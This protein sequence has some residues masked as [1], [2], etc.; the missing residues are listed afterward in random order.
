MIIKIPQNNIPERT[1]IIDILIGEFLGLSYSIEVSEATNYHLIF[2]EKEV[3]VEDNFFNHYQENLAYL[4]SEAIPVSVTF[5]ENQFT[6]ELDVPVLFGNEKIIVEDNHII[7]GNDIFAA[8]FF[9]LTRWEEYV[10][11]ARDIH[12]RFSAKDSL[13][14]KFDFL[15]RPIVNE[16]VEM[17][18]GMLAYLGYREQRK[19]RKY[20][21]VLTHDV[22]HLSYWKGPMRWMQVLG[23]DLIKRKSLLL[24]TKSI[25]DL[26]QT[27]LGIKND[28]YDTFDWI[29]DLSEAANIKSRF[30]FM[31]SDKSDN[32]NRYDIKS[33]LAIGILNKIK[34][35]G[36][37]IGF[38]PSFDSYNNPKRWKEEKERLE[39]TVELPIKEGRQHYLR[40]DSTVTWDIWNRNE[41]ESDLTLSFADK[42]GFRCGV[43]FEFS[44]FNFI[45]QSKLRLK[46]LPL[47]VMEGSFIGY[48]DIKP[49]EMYTRTMNLIN[50][51]KKY[52]G[53]FVFLWHNSSFNVPLW[54]DYEN[55]Y[56]SIISGYAY[57]E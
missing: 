1:Y 2:N 48:Q 7:C 29:M 44:V 28:P 14:Y 17:L 6:S 4:N 46:E 8:S 3:V 31:S 20:E 26:V 56:K 11:P 34:K 50:T 32:D 57:E 35:R 53:T 51:V 9:M 42:E 55:V 49:V 25:K 13:A 38:H 41:M 16:Y 39:E 54:A 22:D 47:T 12:N 37:I 52:N 36:H 15:D 23:A 24:F 33:P 40:F 45:E 21:F 18:W 27:K 30:Y 10:N 5:A 43:C 19:E